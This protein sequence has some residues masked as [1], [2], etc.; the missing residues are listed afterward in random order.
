MNDLEILHDAWG[1][2]EPPTH[3]AQAEARAALL[4]RAHRRRPR[5]PRITVRR[6]TA[7]AAA[8]AIAL[9]FVV[10]QNIDLGDDG[11]QRS[12]VPGVPAVPTASAEVLERAAVAAEQEPFTPPRDDQWIFTEDKLTGSEGGEPS[13]RVQWRRADGGGFAILGEHGKL[14]VEEAPARVKDRERRRLGPISGPLASYEGTAGLPSDSDELLRLVYEETEIVTGAGSTRHA[15]AYAI[16][17]GIIGQGVLPPD[18]KAAAYRAMKEIPG[19]RVSTVDVL[20]EPTISLALTD[21]W[22]RQEMLLDPQ[23]YTFRGQ[24]STAVKTSFV[25]KE[26]AVV[27]K[28]HTVVDERVGEGIVDRPGQRP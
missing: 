22:L 6:M 12:V 19:V 18:L 24:R 7:V 20:G 27:E 21:E 25:A 5:L 2:P 15:E 17:R 1:A 3:T 23:T 10:A 9:G 14:H 28:G 8:V 11:R 26:K 4:A 13:R 16:L